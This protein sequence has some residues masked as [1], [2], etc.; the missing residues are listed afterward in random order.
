LASQAS[1][2]IWTKPWAQAAAGMGYADQSHMIAEFR[3]FGGLTPHELASQDW[4]HPFI[5]RAAGGTALR[6]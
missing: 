5:E 6:P 1:S 3:R 2:L 4:F